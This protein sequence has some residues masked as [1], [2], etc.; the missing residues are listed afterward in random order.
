MKD[1]Y[2][3]LLTVIMLF[4]YPTIQQSRLLLKE[5]P[6]PPPFPHLMWY[7]VLMELLETFMTH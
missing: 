7:R 5:S 1:T 3:E 6:P 2:M 4:N